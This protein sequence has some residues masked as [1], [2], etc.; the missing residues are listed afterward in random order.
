MHQRGKNAHRA[1]E[2]SVVDCEVTAPVGSSCVARSHRSPRLMSLVGGF[3]GFGN[4]GTPVAQPAFGGRTGRLTVHVQAMAVGCLNVHSLLEKRVSE[5]FVHL[6]QFW[7]GGQEA[8]RGSARRSRSRLSAASARWVCR[9][10]G[11][12]LVFLME[13]CIE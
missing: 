1:A 7:C 3:G 6:L 9:A 12:F 2:L 8:S 10:L 13:C 4:F 11:G 5:R